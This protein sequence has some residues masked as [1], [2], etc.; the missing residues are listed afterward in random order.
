LIEEAASK[1]RRSHKVALLLGG[2]ALRRPGLIA[3]DRIKKAIG[4]DLFASTIPGYME[5]GAGLP[6]VERI[7]YFPEQ[8]TAVLSQYGVVLMAGAEEPV[9]FF[10]YPGV[11]SRILT[12]EQEKIRLCTE[13]QNVIEVLES[14]AESVGAPTH[15]AK[16]DNSH[17]SMERPAIPSGELTAEKVCLTLA[18]LQP[19]Y[20]IIV[21]EA[22]S[23][24][25]SY[26][27]LSAKLPPHT[28]LAA[29]GGSLGYGIPCA[30]G[31]AI[32]CP[33]RAVIDLQ[34]D[35]SALYSVQAL[36]TQAREG[37]NVT[38]LICSNRSYKILQIE[39]HRSGITSYGPNTQKL[40]ELKDPSM[41]WVQIAMGFGVP[42]VT[43]ITAEGLARELGKA[44]AESGPH[45]IEM[46]LP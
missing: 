36:W 31:A 33:D 37:L 26:F 17:T 39:L 24:R 4:C 7:P 23:T 41:N 15:L 2:R 27:P 29:A 38:T 1:L 14:L 32:A 16:G 30:A 10:G 18:A 46:V 13:R 35:G 8:A 22:V 6:L 19:E 20:A 9:T 44:L 25:Y 11:R 28:I 43:V 21:D 42:G 12:D 45:L 34:A 40:T 3:A 5:N